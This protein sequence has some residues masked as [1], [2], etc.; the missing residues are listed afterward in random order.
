MANN[1]FSPVTS[2]QK[3]IN[4]NCYTYFV[5]WY[6]LSTGHRVLGP[7]FKK[8][9]GQE[10]KKKKKKK[11]KKTKKAKPGPRKRVIPTG[12]ALR[13]LGVDILRGTFPELDLRNPTS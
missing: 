7:Y 3:K 10:K 8:S 1:S 5:E 9:G 4:A 2:R 13:G 6:K 12:R 11:K